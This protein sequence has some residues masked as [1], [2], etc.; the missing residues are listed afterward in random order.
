MKITLNPSLYFILTPSLCAGRP[1]EDVALAA[2]KGG[3]TLLQL[4]DKTDQALNNAKKL[5][6]LNLHIPLIINDHVHI[7]K[8]INADGAHIGQGDIPAAEAHEIL[9]PNNILGI[10]AFTPEHIVAIDPTIVD[11]IG[12]GPFFPT[13]TDKG[14]PVLGPEKFKALATL[15]PVPTIAIGGIIPENAHE[16]LSNGAGGL[17]IMR[18]IS[19]AK[20][21]E[22]AVKQFKTIIN[23]T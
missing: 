23:D 7:A 10:T 9:G 22:N 5:K 18:A 2:V 13:Q 16:P 4:R 20:D 15:S 11:Y 3:I 12:T 21:V 6:A 19:E 17:A 14:K 1:I 8:Q